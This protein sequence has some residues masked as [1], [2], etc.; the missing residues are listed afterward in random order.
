ML[1]DVVENSPI[2]FRILIYFATLFLP[3][4]TPIYSTK[5]KTMTRNGSEGL[6]RFFFYS[7]RVSR[8]FFRGKKQFLDGQNS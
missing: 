8:T 2:I 7:F 4:N 1:M 3:S 6:I 5:G